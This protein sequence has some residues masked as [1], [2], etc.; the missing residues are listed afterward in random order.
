MS[1]TVHLS[2][3][4]YELLLALKG[5]HDSFSDVV[6]RELGHG[7]DSLKLLEMGELL[8]PDADLD[9]T[10]RRREQAEEDRDSQLRDRSTA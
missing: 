10:R 3:E 6:V 4:A 8:D 5:P 2:D 7:Q 1:S 9:E